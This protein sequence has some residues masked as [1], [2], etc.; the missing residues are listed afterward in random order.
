ATPYPERGEP[1]G[2]VAALL[3]ALYEPLMQAVYVHGSLLSYAALLED[4]FVYQPAD[5][6]IRG[7]LKIADLPDIAA[8]LAPRPLWM[9]CL[10]DGCNRLATPAQLE[11]THY[12]ARAAYAQMDQSNRVTIQAEK[13]SEENISQ[14]LMTH[15]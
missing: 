6:I 15:L 11:E 8:A 12:L 13:A 9:E 4:P 7:L 3:A 14:W 2:G 10:V 1:L 5:S